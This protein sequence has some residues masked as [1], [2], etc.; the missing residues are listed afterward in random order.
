M[1]PCWRA[2]SAPDLKTTIVGIA[3]IR[4]FEATDGNPSVF[5]FA[6]INFPAASAATL[7]NSGATIL[8][9]PHQG[10]Q[11]STKTG[12]LDRMVRALKAASVR[13][14]TGMLGSDIGC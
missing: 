4:N 1:A 8:Q 3:V 14:S 11:K 13:R 2:T 10:A 9:G 6:T 5:T 7:P 12:S